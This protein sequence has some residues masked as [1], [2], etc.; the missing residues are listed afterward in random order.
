MENNILIK[1][2]EYVE[3]GMFI[4]PC[5][6][7]DGIPFKDRKGRI[8][9]SRAKS[10]YTH[11]GVLD[12]SNRIDDIRNWWEKWPNACIGVDCGKSNLFVIDI[13]VKNGKNGINNFMSMGISDSGAW[14]SR[15]PSMGIHIIFSGSG[16]TSTNPKTGIDTRGEGGYFIAPPSYVKNMGKYIA[17][18]EWNNFPISIT[19][20]SLEKLNCSK[21]IKPK[22]KHIIIDSNLSPEETIKKIK[23]ALDNLP[24]YMCDSYQDW[25]NVGMSL[26][27]L[28]DSGLI[29][30]DQWSQKSSKYVDGDC[31][32]KWDTF[33]VKEIGLGSLFFWSKNK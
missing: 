33:S 8:K 5:R 24:L 4:F 32:E 6:E 27:T 15:T 29:L 25:I 1:S 11:N 26:Y 10:P 23:I 7:K 16:K 13:D 30:W 19:E 28:G 14:H 17:T 31:E 3:Q 20:Y 9:L 18:D 21:Y 2:L 22:N 12:S